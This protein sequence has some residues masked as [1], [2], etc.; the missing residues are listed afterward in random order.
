MPVVVDSPSPHWK[1]LAQRTVETVLGRAGVPEGEVSVTFCGD[2]FIRELNRAYMGEDAPTDVLSFPLH[3]AGKWREEYRRSREE[4]RPFLLGEIVI[5][6]D[7]AAAQAQER[8]VEVEEEV[9]LLLVHGALHLLGYD[10]HTEEEARAME[11]ETEACLAAL[12][13]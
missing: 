5:S 10:H 2:E 11:E 12:S 4:G 8:G 9:A 1:E 6:L 3:E 7:R 13:G